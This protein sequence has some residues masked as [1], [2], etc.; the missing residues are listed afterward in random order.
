MKSFAALNTYALLSISLTATVIPS[1]AQ[2]VAVSRSSIASAPYGKLP[3]SFEANQGQADPSV[4]FV[5]HGQGYS[6]LLRAGEALL[7]IQ[8][9]KPGYKSVPAKAGMSGQPPTQAQETSLVRLSLVD[10]NPNARAV[11]ED[12][13]ITRTN[14]FLGNDPTR[15]R[16]NLPNYGRVRYHS[17]YDGIDLVY[18]GNQHQIEHDFVV[19]PKADPAKILL[20]LNGGESP[21]IDAATGDLILTAGSGATRSELRLLKPVAYQESG[22]E[23]RPISSCYKLLA[24]NRI[25]FS[26]G[27]YNHTQ[28]LI[29]DPVLVYSTYF[30]GSGFNGNGDQGNGIAV[31]SSGNAYVVG[32]TYSSN[33]PLTTEPFQAQNAV[34][35]AGH[36]STVFVAK[37]NAAGTA[38]LYSSYLGGSGSGSGGDFGY[39]IALDPQNNVYV[40]GTTYSTDFPVTCGAFQTAN[41]STTSGAPTAFVTKLNPSTNALTY[42]TYLG[43]TGNHATPGQ[44][45]VAEAIAVDAKGNAYLTGY[46]WSSDF[47]VTDAAF[48]TKSLGG[49][50][51]SN[52]FV[53]KLNPGGT[54]LVFSTFLGGGGS[55]GAGDYGNAVAINAAEDTFVTG[56][57]ASPNFPV[58]T[59]A[60]QMALNGSSNAFVTELNSDGTDEVYSTYLGGTGGD[61]ARAIAVDG[62]G[63]AYVAGNTS[64]SDFPLTAGV[65]EDAGSGISKYLGA[66]WSGAFVTKLK[67]DGTAL[68]YSTYLEG[69][70]TTVTGLAVDSHGSAY[71]TGT[72]AA[73]G[74]G[75]FAGFQVTPD[76][77]Q[78]PAYQDGSAFL[79]K[80]NPSATVLNYATLL[81]GSSPDGATAIALDTAG[82]AYLTG[83]ASSTDFPT[84]GGAFQVTKNSA[85]AGVGNAFVSK[86]VLAL[87]ANRTVYPAFPS[88]IQ[89]ALSDSGAQLSVT[90]YPND[91]S[92]DSWSFSV[93]VSLSVASYGPPMTGTLIFYDDGGNYSEFSP[94]MVPL[95]LDAGPSK[96]ALTDGLDYDAPTGPFYLDWFVYYLGDPVYAASSDSGSASSP[97]CPPPSSLV[98]GSAS[99]DHAPRVQ[100]HLSTPQGKGSSRSGLPSISVKL[101]VAGPKFVPLLSTRQISAKENTRSSGVSPAT[102]N[103]ATPAC[104]APKPLLAVNLENNWR[105]YGAP[106]PKFA[107]TVSGLLNGDEVTITPQSAATPASFAG[108]YPVTAV[109]SGTAA[110]NYT[111]TESAATLTVTKAPLYISAKN[112]AVTYGQTPALPFVYKF[113]GFVNGDTASLVSGAPLLTAAV[114]ATSPVGFY[115]IKVQP[116]TLATANYYFDTFSNGEGSVGVYK[117]PLTVRPANFTIHAGDPLPAFTYTITGFLNGENQA[118]ATSG[119]P[120]L[121]TT[122]PSTAVPGRY[123]I[124]GHVGSLKAQNYYFTQPNAAT[125]GILTILK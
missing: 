8:S 4:Q 17:V 50:L 60:F 93:N 64:S 102:R 80:L 14:Y 73:S 42:S 5:S 43:G 115:P 79:V 92:S 51:T 44:G 74:A 109:V 67:T 3:I 15:W 39:G 98:N 83:S 47:P 38:L 100:L 29:I 27:R 59:G 53:T 94:D 69:L 125:N 32:T 58:T 89:T 85:A 16:T 33:F 7:A 78:L 25:G 28:P 13:Q 111:V 24:H 48:Q 123:Y 62:Q 41:E 26:I 86:F 37:F 34:A 70:N 18:Y 120:T 40:T 96:Y 88:T 9:L 54:A 106:N 99:R 2:S 22:R 61:S 49:G 105:L 84:T 10:A 119:A 77:L 91:I 12:Q 103:E 55:H 116:G 19:G 45:D 63:F 108:S 82:N 76:A 1:L 23:R 75:R 31:D 6:F 124:I 81:G 113:A 57:T 110:A 52:A 71:V 122:A 118:S 20:S 72:A 21:R 66:N 107:Y 121:T 104:L 112:V 36:G 30:G 114:T 101:S 46:T 35:R 117:A 11:A 95:P 65:L 68:E 87:E 97:G 56:S 90:C